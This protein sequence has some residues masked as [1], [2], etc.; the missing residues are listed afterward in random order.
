MN[1]YFSDGSND[2]SM[3]Y[4]NNN[5]YM[6]WSGVDNLKLVYGT[7][8]SWTDNLIESSGSPETYYQFGHLCVDNTG[9]IH[10][11][12]HDMQYYPTSSRFIYANNST[13]SFVKVLMTDNTAYYQYVNIYYA[14]NALVMVVSDEDTGY[15]Y[16]YKVV[17]SASNHAPMFQYDGSN[18]KRV[19]KLQNYNSGFNL[20]KSTKYYIESNWERVTI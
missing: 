14:N 4:Y 8:G 20:S 15:I 5:V 6:L 17:Q 11:A 13:G 19:R 9:I 7:S 2:V 16:G 12:V 10:V 18:F 3:I 1:T